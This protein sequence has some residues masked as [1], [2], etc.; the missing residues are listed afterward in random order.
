MDKGREVVDRS[1]AQWEEFVERGKSLV[2]EKAGR[3][4]SAVEAGQ[5]AYNA[6]ASNDEITG[7]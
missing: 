7:A 3:V 1:R 5:Q 6:S 2:T 4:A